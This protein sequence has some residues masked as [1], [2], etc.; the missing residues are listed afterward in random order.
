MILRK[1]SGDTENIAAPI[2]GINTIA[3]LETAVNPTIR[4]KQNQIYINLHNKDDRSVFRCT[5][6]AFLAL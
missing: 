2:A 6:V 3:R 4:Q 1:R 5:F